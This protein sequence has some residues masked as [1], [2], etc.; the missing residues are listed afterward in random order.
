MRKSFNI[1][2]CVNRSIQSRDMGIRRHSICERLIYFS[3]QLVLIL[4]EMARR[5]L[6]KHVHEHL[7]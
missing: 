7:T 2:V 4:I 1:F 5:F 3:G 6:Q